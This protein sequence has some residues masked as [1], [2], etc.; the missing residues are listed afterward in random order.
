M[1]PADYKDEWARYIQFVERLGSSG[2]ET[3]DGDSSLSEPTQSI[4]KGSHATE[5][6]L[7]NRTSG[8]SEHR[9]TERRGRVLTP[10]DGCSSDGNR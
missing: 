2:L 4:S 7:L 6:G 5:A 1:L 3:D 10:N 9:R 8:G